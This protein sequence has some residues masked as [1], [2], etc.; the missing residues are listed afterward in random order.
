MKIAV[1]GHTSGIGKS[2]YD[3]FLEQNN[4]VIGF[5]R[6]NGYNISNKEDRTNI[7]NLSE[8]FDIFV[9]NAYNNFDNS[10]ELMLA[11][12]LESWKDTEKI[13]I[14]LSSR[15]TTGNHKYC[16][17]KMS[18]DNICNEHLFSKIYLI[19]LK[20]GLIDTPR[21]SAEK[22]AKLKTK[23]VV[24]IIDFIL[25]NKNEFKIHSITFGK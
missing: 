20:P 2:I 13:I 14:N 15:W 19:N 24:D 25:L 10:Q 4:D 23:S 16:H 5:S 1:T 17:D 9:N 7:C 12:R 8:N 18:I 22:G 21:V 3:Y 11:D 6:S